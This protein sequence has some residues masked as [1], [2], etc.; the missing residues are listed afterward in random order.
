MDM[1]PVV[2]GIVAIR[3]ACL[4]RFENCMR[5]YFNVTRERVWSLDEQCHR[6]VNR[7]HH[8]RH[9]GA[10]ARAFAAGLGAEEKLAIRKET[11][12]RLR[13]WPRFLAYMCTFILTQGPGC[14]F[15]LLRDPGAFDE[16]AA[17]NA[18]VFEQVLRDRCPEALRS[19]SRPKPFRPT[20]SLQP[21]QPPRGHA[22]ERPWSAR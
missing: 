20:H 12:R 6:H 9:D 2:R 4:E 15:N 22:D 13:L 21:S 11:K 1:C 7:L 10:G 8:E 17:Q 14:V 5:L 16:W 3:R 18:S 19:R